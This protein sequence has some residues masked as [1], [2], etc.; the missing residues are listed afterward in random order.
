MYT[1]KAALNETVQLVVLF[2]LPIQTDCLCRALRR[3]QIEF[4]ESF[5]FEAIQRKDFR[6][7]ERNIY[8]A[9]ALIY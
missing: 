1:F 5:H 9:N 6:I 2:E 4:I 3:V 8:G 7:G